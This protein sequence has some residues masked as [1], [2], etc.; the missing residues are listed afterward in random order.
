MNKVVHFEVPYDDKEKCKEFYHK[1]FDWKLQD[2]PEMSYTIAHTVE[3]DEK[4]MPKEVGAINGG[5]YKRDAK[6]AKGPLIVIDVTSV[7]EYLKKVK[8]AGGK[9][10]REKMQVGDMGW[11]AQVV[12]TEE[13][14]IGIW[15]TIKK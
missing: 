3:V 6:S 7:D 15:Q 11:Y 9:V 4:Q 14:I 5:M 13:N 2:I 12:D 1:V 10:F 8:K